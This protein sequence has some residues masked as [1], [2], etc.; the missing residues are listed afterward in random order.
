MLR[1]AVLEKSRFDI[2]NCTEVV[3]REVWQI[4]IID[5]AALTLEDAAK[6]G[7][8]LAAAVLHSRHEVTLVCVAR[9]VPRLSDMDEFV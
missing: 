1:L 3:D 6:G 7:G 2:F 8:V 4:E 5:L 9:G